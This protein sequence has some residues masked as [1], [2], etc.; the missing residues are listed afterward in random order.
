MKKIIMLF[1][2]VFVIP[3]FSQ[4]KTEVKS[5]GP[6]VEEV[7]KYEGPKARI[8]V[9][10]F[11]VKS[12][13]ATWQMGEGL[14]D[15]LIDAL[16]KSGKFIVLE[17]GEDLKEL[18]DEFKYSESGWTQKKLEKGTFEV[19]D[20]IVVGAITGF[21]PYAEGTGGGGVVVPLPFGL[22]VGVKKEEAYIQATIRLIDVRTRRIINSTKVE[23]KYSKSKLGVAGGGAIGGVILGGGF[24]KYKNTPTEQAVMI[25]IDNAV[26][27]IA[28]MV[29][30]SYYRYGEKDITYKNEPD[31]FRGI[32]WT[33]Q[34]SEIAGLK[35]IKEDG[36]YK[37][38][39][40]PDD[41]LQIGKAK[42]EKIVYVFYRDQL[43]SVKIET[44]GKENF[45]NLKAAA[46]EKFGDATKK[47][48]NEWK[49][50]GKVT[51]INLKYDDK[52]EKGTMIMSSEEMKKKTEAGF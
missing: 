18:E 24:E 12:P 26:K 1:L 35:K 10:K 28:R 51:S 15:M 36:D 48:V 23:G 34:L 22:G 44:K 11:E 47:E 9:S 42:L 50:E 46:I 25:M 37:E 5:Q 41:V 8:A 21:E 13:K 39:V 45:E 7:M 33:T 32:K 2:I 17:K 38:F 6:S 30:E 4:V 29:P 27:E 16:F 31:G 52:E 14:R 49:W 20:I 40:K 19:A 43:E 3:L